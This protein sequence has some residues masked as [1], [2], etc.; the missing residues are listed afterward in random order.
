VTRLARRRSQNRVMDSPTAT[1]D[2]DLDFER[3]RREHALLIE[4]IEVT[5]TPFAV[6]DDQDRL[7]AWN[8]PYERV[9]AAAFS[10][11]RHKADSRTLHYPDLVRVIAEATLAPAE[12][13]AYVAQRVRD[14]RNSDGIGVDRH[15]PDVGWYRVSKFKTRGGGIAGF[16]IDINEHKRRELELEREVSRR[17]ALEEALRVQANT[18]SLTHLASRGAFLERGRVDFGRARRSNDKLCVIMMDADHFKQVNDAHGHSAGD[19]VLAA[20][21]DTAMDAA[22]KDFDLV[23][24]IGGEEFAMIMAQ[25]DLQEAAACAERIRTRLAARTFKSTAGNFSITASFG[26]AQRGPQDGSFASLLN[27][28]D[29]ALYGAKHSGRN[30]VGI[31]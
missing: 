4:S 12:V 3:I 25:A 31:S 6:Y 21:A 17:M 2:D 29:Q 8:K 9:H 1:I 11:L 26:A 5:P 14:Q 10:R 16:A 23:G 20:F 19:R 7:I 30:R 15:Y 24:R 28:A 22:R 13:D 27:R 18:D